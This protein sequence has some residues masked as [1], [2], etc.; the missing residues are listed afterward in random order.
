[1]WTGTMKY[2][3]YPSHADKKE[4]VNIN[5]NKKIHIESQEVKY[6]SISAISSKR[7]AVYYTSSEQGIIIVWIII[8]VIIII[9]DKFELK[10]EKRRIR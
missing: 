5:G 3:G 1:V 9:I 6:G 4:V 7:H 10:S 8:I 2:I